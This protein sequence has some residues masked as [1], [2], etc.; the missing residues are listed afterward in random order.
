MN[1]KKVLNPKTNRFVHFGSQKFNRLVMEGVIKPAEEKAVEVKA[2][3]P[4]IE[5]PIKKMLA[6]ELTTIVKQ[7]MPL[8]EKEM[9][10]KES[11]A[12]LRKLLYEKLCIK[13]TDKKTKKKKKFKV[14]APPPS[15][16]SE[17]SE[18]SD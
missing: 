3:E 16:E 18:S 7:N 1:S 5:P 9:T 14:R 17:S 11:D 2:E 13:K 10:Q 12:L 8:F 4:N 15:S 6:E